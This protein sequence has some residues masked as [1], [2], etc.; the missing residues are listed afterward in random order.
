MRLPYI[1]HTQPRTSL[2][3]ATSFNFERTVDNQ[4][5]HIKQGTSLNI[6]ASFSDF[7]LYLSLGESV[8]WLVKYVTIVLKPYRQQMFIC[9]I[10]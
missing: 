1:K 4:S 8:K 10:L 7:F 9:C 3:M 6:K 5:L 2:V